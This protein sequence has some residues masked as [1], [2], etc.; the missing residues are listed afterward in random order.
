M[1][2][3]TNLLHEKIEG[4]DVDL[5]PEMILLQWFN[6]HLDRA[7][8]P[9]HV[10]DFAESVANCEAYAALLNQIAPDHCGIEVVGEILREQDLEK[11]AGLL[12]NVAEKIGC[13]NFVT[14][15]DIV[16]VKNKKTKPL[17]K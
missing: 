3:N 4:L 1:K 5:P 16:E 10:K 7:H 2:E 13:K 14:P 17:S 9:R 15:K 6:Y 11:R 8:H 12:L